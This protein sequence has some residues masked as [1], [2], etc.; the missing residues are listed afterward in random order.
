[1]RGGTQAM[2]GGA[3]MA[4]V[5]WTVGSQFGWEPTLYFVPLKLLGAGIFATGLVLR[6]GWDL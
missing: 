1:M 4:F 3:F 6:F 5:G 2:I